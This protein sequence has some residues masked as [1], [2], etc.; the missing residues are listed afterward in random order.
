MA[1][2]DEGPSEGA[3][4]YGRG[5]FSVLLRLTFNGLEFSP[6]PLSVCVYPKLQPCNTLAFTT[7]LAADVEGAELEAV[8]VAFQ[9]AAL[10]GASPPIDSEEKRQEENLPEE[11][12]PEADDK[13]TPL[14]RVVVPVEEDAIL[15]PESHFIAVA[16]ECA[17]GA[18]PYK[19]SARLLVFGDL[20]SATAASSLPAAA[21]AGGSLDS[22]AGEAA[23]EKAGGVSETR[24]A[25]VE[26]TVAAAVC[27]SGGSSAGAALLRLMESSTN[28]AS[29]TRGKRGTSRETG[30]APLKAAPAT[31][32][33][34]A[35]GG[36]VGASEKAKTQVPVK[37][38]PQPQQ[39]PQQRSNTVAIEAQAEKA[40]QVLTVRGHTN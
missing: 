37:G 20:A 28:A 4:R 21:N 36:G 15:T 10:S 35:V 17:G 34:S 16:F 9:V 33:A 38:K 40:L 18:P 12:G 5:S 30:K 11:E 7:G 13:E 1:R 29:R 32:K 26:V 23:G 6:T 19:P 25:R 31:K 14:K 8:A 24:E 39:Q 27:E 2:E 22:A 3:F